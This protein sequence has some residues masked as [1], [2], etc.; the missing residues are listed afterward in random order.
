LPF[1][2]TTLFVG[3]SA[4]VYSE[5]SAVVLRYAS[6]QGRFVGLGKPQGQKDCAAGGAQVTAVAG[7]QE[8]S[9]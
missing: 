9:T 5:L 4:A 6:R 8:Q 1:V 7:L 3:I 2:G